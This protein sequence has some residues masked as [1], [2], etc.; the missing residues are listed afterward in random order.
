VV[1]VVFKT[2]FPFTTRAGTKTE[3][4]IQK[5]NQKTTSSLEFFLRIFFDNYPDNYPCTMYHAPFFNVVHNAGIIL[6]IISEIILKEIPK[7]TRFPQSAILQGRGRTIYV[8]SYYCICVFM[9]R[10]QS[11]ILQGRGRIV[12]SLICANKLTFFFFK[13]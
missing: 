13:R 5:E 2:L 11:A 4:E 7:R 6:K 3:P 10:P 8:S 1:D 9:P 12:T